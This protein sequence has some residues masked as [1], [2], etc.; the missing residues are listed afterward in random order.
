MEPRKKGND[1]QPT[2]E[3]AIDKG[4]GPRA[5]LNQGDSITV[6]SASNIAFISDDARYSGSYFPSIP[7]D[8]L[9]H[10]AGYELLHYP[11]PQAQSECGINCFVF[12]DLI[13][14][15]LANFTNVN[16]EYKGK[17]HKKNVQH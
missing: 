5:I 1:E 9:N 13:E 7:D 11:Q 6:S 17:L 8:T 10:W 2:S 12:Q 4:L 14:H 15:V 3:R 16:T